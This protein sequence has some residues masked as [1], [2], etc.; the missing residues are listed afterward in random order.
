MLFIITE[1]GLTG[2]QSN[3][4]SFA[5]DTDLGEWQ[6]GGLYGKSTVAPYTFNDVARAL[7]PAAAYYGQTGLLPVQLNH[8]EA[9]GGT[10]RISLAQDAPYVKNVN[11]CKITCVAIDANT[12]EVVNAARVK[13]GETMTDISSTVSESQ[14]VIPTENGV[15]V[16]T[17][18]PAIVTIYDVQGKIIATCQVETETQIPTSQKGLLLV[19]IT[20]A[21]GNEVHKVIR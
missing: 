19:K 17:N 8:S 3:G 2:Y 13:V 6:K 9:Y 1:D 20:N 16:K 15:L 21:H 7:Y 11:N 14:I 5:T 12:G 18:S 4:F 10:Q